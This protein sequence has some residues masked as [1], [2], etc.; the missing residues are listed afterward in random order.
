MSQLGRE[1]LLNFF[2]D[3]KNFRLSNQST[4]GLTDEEM[5]ED[6]QNDSQELMDNLNRFFITQRLNKCPVQ[7]LTQI[8]NKN[9]NIFF[10]LAKKIDVVRCGYT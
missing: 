2:N 8:L 5:S 4:D 9:L 1:I 7:G 3:S 10:S 6:E